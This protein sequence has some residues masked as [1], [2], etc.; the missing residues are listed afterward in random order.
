MRPDEARGLARLAGDAAGGIAT[1]S[2]EM[3]AGIAG[4]L[5]GVLGPVASGLRTSHDT[6]AAGSTPALAH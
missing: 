4:R 1:Q 2:Q 6:I 5:F 3:H